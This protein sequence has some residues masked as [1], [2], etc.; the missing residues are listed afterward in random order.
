MYMYK[1]PV[2]S[3]GVDFDHLRKQFH[4]LIFYTTQFISVS[5]MD[6]QSVWWRLFHAP[7]A[8]SWSNILQ[9]VGLILTLP[10]SNVKLDKFFLLLSSLRWTKGPPLA[11]T[12]LTIH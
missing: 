1:N 8:V 4:K 7:A 5:T 9:L 10:I 11:I 3:A 2:E 12:C 6:Y